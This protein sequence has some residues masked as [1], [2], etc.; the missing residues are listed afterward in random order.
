MK[1]SVDPYGIDVGDRDESVHD[2][3][4][5]LELESHGESPEMSGPEA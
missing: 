5:V 4:T 2:C 3:E 1:V